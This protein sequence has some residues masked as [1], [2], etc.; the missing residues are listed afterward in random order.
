MAAAMS[1]FGNKIGKLAFAKR[2]YPLVQLQHVKPARAAQIRLPRTNV[3]QM[4]GVVPNSLLR[5][6]NLVRLRIGR[7][8]SAW[9]RQRLLKTI[10]ASLRIHI[11]PRRFGARRN[12]NRL[13]PERCT[14]SAAGVA[15]ETERVQ[16]PVARSDQP[17]RNL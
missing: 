4:K 3:N 1:G 9:I 7:C 6:R 14:P 16:M 5:D 11:K 8:D 10:Q 17:A 12:A 13:S 15:V 2:S